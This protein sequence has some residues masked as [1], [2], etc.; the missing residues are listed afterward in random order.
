MTQAVSRRLSLTAEV[1]L[2]LRTGPIGI[3][4]RQG[5]TRI[6]ISV[7]TVVYLYQHHSINVLYSSSSSKLLFY[8]KKE[9]TIPPKYWTL[10]M[11]TEIISFR[12]LENKVIIFTLFRVVAK[13]DCYFPHVLLSACLSLSVHLSICPSARVHF[14]GMLISNEMHNS[15]DQFLFHSFLSAL[16]V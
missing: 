7:R 6:G 1:P 4:G 8:Q 3:L 16:H 15:Y 14:H 11:T 10:Y 2:Q 12:K 9:L 13:S 5:L